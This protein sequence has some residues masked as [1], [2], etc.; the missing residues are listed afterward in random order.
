MTY[1]Q[2]VGVEEGVLH[3]HELL[4]TH[5]DLKGGESQTLLEV[6]GQT[7]LETQAAL[8]WPSYIPLTNVAI[9]LS[10]RTLAQ[11][12]WTVWCGTFKTLSAC[13]MWST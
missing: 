11:M 1:M 3:I 13:S 7:G 2:L 12:L 9:S 6:Q 5:R 8:V 10:R 4:V